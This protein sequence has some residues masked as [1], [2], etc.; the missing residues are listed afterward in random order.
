VNALT[1]WLL[2]EYCRIPKFPNSK[3][4][5]ALHA[6]GRHLSHRLV[7]CAVLSDFTVVSRH[8]GASGD[9]GNSGDGDSGENGDRW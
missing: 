2:L 8:S 4:P 3:F 9:S 1:W 5:K 6:L 7:G